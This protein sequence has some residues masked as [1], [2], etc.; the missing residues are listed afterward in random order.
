MSTKQFTIP[1]GDYYVKCCIFDSENELYKHYKEC[2]KKCRRD[3]NYNIVKQ[4]EPYAFCY[5]PSFKICKIH[6]TAGEVCFSKNNLS[7]CIIAHEF[8][9]CLINYLLCKSKSKKTKN[10]KVVFGISNEKN[11]L[12]ADILEKM[13]RIFIDRYPRGFSL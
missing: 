1:I 11:E 9:H 5:L 3:T 2:L 7:I 4:I 6:K 8:F 10:R 13:I 12:C